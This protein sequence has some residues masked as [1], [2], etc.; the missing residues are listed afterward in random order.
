[1]VPFITY[2][3]HDI[4]T[5][6]CFGPVYMLYFNRSRAAGDLAMIR[7]LLM[8]KLQRYIYLFKLSWRHN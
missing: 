4:F 7:S 5:L 3:N 2:N 1:M 8:I 6:R